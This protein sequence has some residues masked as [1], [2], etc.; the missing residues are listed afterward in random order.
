[1]YKWQPVMCGII[2]VIIAVLVTRREFLY[3]AT[4]TH[5]RWFLFKHLC[6]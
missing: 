3:Y 1:M 6:I 5:D 2:V 4:L